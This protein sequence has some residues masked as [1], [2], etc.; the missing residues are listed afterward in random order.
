MVIHLDS[1]LNP[2]KFNLLEMV[3]KEVIDTIMLKNSL[4]KIQTPKSKKKSFLAKEKES[5]I[6]EYQLETKKMTSNDN[7]IYSET[8]IQDTNWLKTLEV[9]LTS[10][11]RD[12]K[13]FWNTQSKENSKN[14]WLPTKTD[15]AVSDL[16]SLNG[17]LRSFPEGKSWFSTK[18]NVP[19]NKNLL[20]MYSLLLMSSQQELMDLENTKIKSKKKLNQKKTK[21]KK[22]VKK[23]KETL[24]KSKVFKM[25]PNKKQKIILNKW[26]GVFRWFYNKTIDYIEEYKIYNFRKV[27]N[28]MRVN[29]KYQIP[30]WCDIDI[31]P[32][33]ITGAIKDCCDAY[34]TCF[35]NRNNGNVKNFKLK[36][37]TKKDLSQC[38]NL[39]KS[40]F[41]KNN[42]IL[43]KYKLGSIKGVYN[44]KKNITLENIKINNDCRFKYVNNK[45]YLNIPCEI[46]KDENQVLGSIISLDSG[47]RTFQTGYS[48]SYHT[49]ELGIG[50]NDV[51]HKDLKK[52]DKLT[53]LTTKIK[54]SKINKIKVRIRRINERI[55]NKI[56][57]LHWKVISFLTRNYEEIYLSDFKIKSI[58]TGNLNS[59]SKRLLLILRHYEF[60]KRL[61]YK[62]KERNTRLNIVD[63]SYT[64][65]T[66]CNCGNLNH[67]LGSSKIYKCDKCNLEL[68]RDINASRN[69]LNKNIRLVELE[70]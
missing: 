1:G 36:Y 41:S 61:E 43:P 12:L 9:E 3:E 31:P 15:Y 66:C 25:Y 2:V 63:E 24:L 59:V 56:N 47:I 14:W 70:L 5:A 44:R 34:K 8:N 62:C 55:R 30:E 7:Q 42:E 4:N 67:L 29:S 6:A 35:S 16:T 64:S 48:P 50:L 52:I 58:L 37:K 13:P 20:P 22:V 17:S 39:E 11:G 68:D 28:N 26:F 51:F 40:C 60:R 65:K 53:S 27:R 46:D 32:R 19:Q 33:I 45:W 49:L 54:K 18:L 38:L 57:D 21:K 69:I 10:R 23:Q